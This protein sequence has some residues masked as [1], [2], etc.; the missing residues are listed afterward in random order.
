MRSDPNPL[1]RV[2][3]AA[4]QV[5]V[6]N[7]LILFAQSGKNGTEI[8]VREF[9]PKD[10][11]KK[12]FALQE[13]AQALKVFAPP[14]TEIVAGT[15]PVLLLIR[16]EGIDLE[17]KVR[18][19]E[20]GLRSFRAAHQRMPTQEEATK[21]NVDYSV[22]DGVGEMAHKLAQSVNFPGSTGFREKAV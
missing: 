11:T 17:E 10:G 1:N 6:E 8:G 18:R 13:I 20:V 19:N 5:L 9:Q 2:E 7:E 3:Q 21:I 16:N 15:K 4:M 14:G 22:D 12:S